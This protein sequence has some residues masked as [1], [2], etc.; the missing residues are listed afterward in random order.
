M[1]RYPLYRRLGGPYGRSGQVRKI[2]P[3]PGFDTRAVQ[4][5]AQS[6]YRLSYPAHL[7]ICSLCYFL[8]QNLFEKKSYSEIIVP[9]MKI[10]A[11]MWR[12]RIAQSAYWLRHGLGIR[13][14]MVRFPAEARMC[15]LQSDPT[16]WGPLPPCFLF[17]WCCDL[18]HGRWIGKFGIATFSLFTLR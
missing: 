3:P 16:N 4:P 18:F 12:F 15:F 8:V 2:L 10:M 7:H 11:W 13:E 9:D 1:T 17:K 6:L 14:I 5:V